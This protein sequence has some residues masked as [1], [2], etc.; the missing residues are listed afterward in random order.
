MPEPPILRR[1]ET[2]R[3]RG[4]E[5]SQGREKRGTGDRP[6]VLGDDLVGGLGEVQVDEI[7]ESRHRDPERVGIGSEGVVDGENREDTRR[8]YRERGRESGDEAFEGLVG[9]GVLYFSS[10]K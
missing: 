1:E 6:Y 2:T 4:D 8:C 3:H 9:L 10:L 7:V 5:I